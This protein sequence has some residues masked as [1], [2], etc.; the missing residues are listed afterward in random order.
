MHLDARLTVRLIRSRSSRTP[1][2]HLSDQS[3]PCY[4]PY[5]FHSNEAVAI[6]HTNMPNTHTHTHTD[7]PRVLD[8]TMSI[9]FSISLSF[10]QFSRPSSVSHVSRDLLFMLPN[11]LIDV[12]L[13]FRRI[14]RQLLVFRCRNVN[15]FS[16]DCLSRYQRSSGQRFADIGSDPGPFQTTACSSHRSTSSTSA[17]FTQLAR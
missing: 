10:H 7:E 5:T 2:C 4:R 17:K 13:R 11:K 14:I 9:L 1:I 6:R 15:A 12:A 16:F 3:A 8:L